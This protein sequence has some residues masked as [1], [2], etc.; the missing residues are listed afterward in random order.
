MK[1]KYLFYLLLSLSFLF[2]NGKQDPIDKEQITK[3]QNAFDD[4]IK[5]ASDSNNQ[6]YAYYIA[7]CRNQTFKDNLETISQYIQEKINL[8][9]LPEAKNALEKLKKYKDGVS[10]IKDLEKCLNIMD[11]KSYIDIAD[12]ENQLTKQEPLTGEKL[13]DNL[14]TFTRQLQV[15][16]VLL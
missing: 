11:S 5:I 3:I 9:A 15:L 14:Q 2:A 12:L 4:Q 8:R 1:N 7:V 13:L 6:F 16:K 10:K